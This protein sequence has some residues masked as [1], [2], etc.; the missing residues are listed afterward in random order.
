M[1]ESKNAAGNPVTEQA[2]I[3]YGMFLSGVIDF[4]ILAIVIFIAL[5]VASSFMNSAAKDIEPSDEVK[6]LT[7]ICDSLAN[8]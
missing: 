5:K 2:A 8:Q 7:E 6:L 4:T 3:L 1:I